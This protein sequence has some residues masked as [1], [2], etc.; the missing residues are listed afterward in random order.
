MVGRVFEHRLVLY[1]RTFRS[2]IFS[3]FLSPVLFL[4]AMG[5][6]LGSYVSNSASLGGVPYL[7]FLAPGLLAAACMQTAAFESSFPITGR[8]VW[9]RGYEAVMAT[10][11]SV[12]DVV[13]GELG[14]VVPVLDVALMVK[15]A[16]VLPGQLAVEGDV[17]Q[18][19]RKP[20][21][22]RRR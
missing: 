8:M 18:P 15:P 7:D 13:L 2:S 12:R 6:G 5:L 20:K 9:H 17:A 4:T 1:R 11:M 21:G 19:R 14:G 3:S 22:Q 10:P 16:G